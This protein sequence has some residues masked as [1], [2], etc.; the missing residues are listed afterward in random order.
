MYT[1]D[2]TVVVVVKSYSGVCA[3]VRLPDGSV[4]EMKADQLRY[5]KPASTADAER[6][7]WR[8]EPATKKQIAYLVRMGVEIPN[9]LTKGSASNLIGAAKSGDLGSF[10]GWRTDGSN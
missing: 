7:D 4:V 9:G 2:G 5:T 1:Q 10:G 6:G 3:D 8:N